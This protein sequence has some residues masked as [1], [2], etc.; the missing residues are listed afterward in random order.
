M[1]P[2]TTKR[3]EGALSLPVEAQA[4]LDEAERRAMRRIQVGLPGVITPPA[5]MVIQPNAKDGSCRPARDLYQGQA[6][7]VERILRDAL[8][9]LDR[10]RRF[11][12]G[13]TAYLGSLTLRDR[14]DPA[15]QEAINKGLGAQTIFLESIESIRSALAAIDDKTVSA[16]A[17]ASREQP[18]GVEIEEATR[19]VARLAKARQK[20][21][22]RGRCR[23]EP[24]DL[25]GAVRALE[26]V[27]SKPLEPDVAT[28][29]EK[30]FSEKLVKDK[31]FGPIAGPKKAAEQVVSRAV[32]ED[33]RHARD[34]VKGNEPR[35]RARKHR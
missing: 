5:M 12:E 34:R 24:G 3:G 10:D 17:E 29:I 27:A 23:Y 30:Q 14:A 13:T 19:A 31:L 8:E 1:K 25:E 26:A 28:W 22:P 11:L 21:G 4:A 35:K 18:R 20:A 32:G 2:R 9:T 6:D 7:R 15:S 16:I 33:A